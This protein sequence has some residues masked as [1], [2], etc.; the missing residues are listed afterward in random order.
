MEILK[1]VPYLT[2]RIEDTLKEFGHRAVYPEHILITLTRDSDDKYMIQNMDVDPYQLR[3]ELCSRL[4]ENIYDEEDNWNNTLNLA[5]SGEASLILDKAKQI[6]QKL[7]IYATEEN[8]CHLLL[9][10]TLSRNNSLSIILEEHGL[11]VKVVSQSLN[12]IE[13]SKRRQGPA[14]RQIDEE[15]LSSEMPEFKQ[16]DDS[17]EENDGDSKQ[18]RQ[19]QED[20]EKEEKSE[21]PK[22]SYPNLDKYALD[23]TEEEARPDSQPVIG[24]DA[25]IGHMIETLLRKLSPNPLIVGDPGVGKTALVKGLAQRIARGEVPESFKRTKIFS[26]TASELTAGTSLRGDFEKRMK[27]IIQEL[28]KHP[29]AILFIDEIHMICGAGAAGGRIDAANILKPALADGRIRCIGATTNKHAK[30]ITSDEALARRFTRIKLE[31]PD[32]ENCFQIVKGVSEWLQESHDVGYGDDSIEAAI[33]GAQRYLGDRRLPDSAIR[34]LDACGARQNAVEFPNRKSFIGISEIED[35][36]SDE[37][38]FEIHLSS[39]SEKKNLLALESNVG[40]EVFGQDQAIATVT[41]SIIRAKAGLNDPDRPIASFIFSGPTGVGKSELVKVLARKLDVNIFRLDMSE[42]MEKH[43]V[44]RLIGA[45]PGYVGY[46]QN[47]ILTD[48][49]SRNPH[50]VLLFDEIEKSHEDIYDI[51]LQIMADGALTDNTGKTVDFRN[52]ILI[53]TSNVSSRASQSNSLGFG[54]SDKQKK[55]REDAVRKAIK[56]EFKPEFLGRVDEIVLFNDLDKKTVHMIADKFIRQIKQRLAAR[57]VNMEITFEAREEIIRQGYDTDYGAR[58][59]KKTV[60]KLLADSIA[61]EVIFGKLEKGGEILFHHEEGRDG[62]CRYFNEEA[63]AR[64]KS[65][66]QRKNSESTAQILNFR[67]K[68]V[69]QDNTPALRLPEYG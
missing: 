1:N 63:R 59:L 51:L 15:Y 27:A 39:D 35:V 28:T 20:G 12:R 31:P 11:N 2:I 21:K 57:G 17:G 33:S 6:S 32:R 62:L 18:C 47:G 43:S 29:N 45:P 13:S 3:D 30:I 44:S 24:R 9:L 54:D 53:M 68:T 56:S 66:E 55:D 61:R 5:W 41:N 52:V 16:R 10:A 8:I 60:E 50:T 34:V 14:S 48:E 49:I 40:N 22:S 36:I 25:E 46:D 67:P 65:L 58:P 69:T 42:Y 38:G 7:G 23:I 26:T 64:K 4:A 19:C 37:A